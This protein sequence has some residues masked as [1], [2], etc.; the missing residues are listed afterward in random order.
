MA[1]DNFQNRGAEVMIP[2]HK[3]TQIAGFGVES[4]KYHL[5]GLS[6]APTT[7]STTI[8]SMAASGVSRRWSAVTTRAPAH[9]EGH[10]TVVK[11]LIQE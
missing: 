2:K 5:G 1:I 4:I 3:A 7:L 11:E 6:A 8:S 9:N 10:I